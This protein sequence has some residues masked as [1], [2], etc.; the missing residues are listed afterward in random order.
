MLFKKVVENIEW[1][2]IEVVLVIWKE[3]SKVS[4]WMKLGGVGWFFDYRNGLFFFMI[5]KNKGKSVNFIVFF[6]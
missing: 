3:I 2:V 6:Y 5:I 4:D 1:L